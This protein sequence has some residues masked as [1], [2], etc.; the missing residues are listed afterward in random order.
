VR[1]DKNSKIIYPELSY[2]L[3]GSFYKTHNELGRFCREKQYCDFLENIFKSLPIPYQR[4]KAI[5]INGIENNNTNKVDFEIDKLILID[6][7][8]KKFIIR[9]DYNQMK[10]YLKAS[11][12]KLGIIVNFK[13]RS[14][15][16]RR[17]INSEA[18]E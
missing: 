15:R 7:K 18:K 16:P 6:A 2:K 8:A 1:I 17:V 3:N 13:E 14:I 9:E 4:E 5:P 10:R 11:N 12:R